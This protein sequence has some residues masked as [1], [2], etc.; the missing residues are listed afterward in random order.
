MRFA[1]AFGILGVVL[2]ALALRLARDAVGAWWLIVAVET[3]FAACFLTL[4]LLY[5]LRHAGLPVEDLFLHPGWSLIMR[6]LLLPYLV[7]AGITLYLS[8]WID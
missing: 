4:A 5:G 7:L 2:T 3:Y 6:L 8:R 1:I